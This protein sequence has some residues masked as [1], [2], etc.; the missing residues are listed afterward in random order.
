MY[1]ITYLQSIGPQM[2]REDPGVGVKC[3]TILYYYIARAQP[4]IRNILVSIIMV[5]EAVINSEVPTSSQFTTVPFKYPLTE[6]IIIVEINHMV[7][8]LDQKSS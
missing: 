8:C 5:V 4:M 7:S 6:L 1:I 2:A 3:I